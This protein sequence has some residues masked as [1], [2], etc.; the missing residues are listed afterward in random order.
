MKV[1]D[2]VAWI[3][4]D[5][6]MGARGGRMNKVRSRTEYKSKE[7]SWQRQKNNIF[8][9][10]LPKC[11]YLLTNEVWFH[12][13]TLKMRVLHIKALSL[14]A[15][16][17]INRLWHKMPFSDHT[18]FF[19]FQ[20][21]LVNEPGD[22]G[23]MYLSSVI[24]AYYWSQEDRMDMGCL[25]R[26][27]TFKPHI[28]I[29]FPVRLDTRPLRPNHSVFSGFLRALTLASHPCSDT[30]LQ[31]SALTWRAFI[32]SGWG[33]EL[34]NSGPCLSPML[35]PSRVS[36]LRESYCFNMN[37]ERFN[38][39]SGCQRTA[40]RDYFLGTAVTF[41]GLDSGRIGERPK[42]G[43][44]RWVT[45][46]DRQKERDREKERHVERRRLCTPQWTAALQS[47][48]E[49]KRSILTLTDQAEEKA[50]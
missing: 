18:M 48:I 42:L 44:I 38:L 21:D 9:V 2:T 33:E 1:C 50:A 32:I 24:M 12:H 39:S 45:D 6:A 37:N 30:D 10:N 26:L 19:L 14:S 7:K 35:S 13:F 20:H 5:S 23:V 15:Q 31:V 29:Q 47:S 36:P 41:I 43:R 40:K 34:D 22:G 46:R 28:H 16:P 4:A 17:D 49:R 11:W 3:K 8:I 25:R 27:Q